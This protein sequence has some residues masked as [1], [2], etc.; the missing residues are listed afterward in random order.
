MLF[1]KMQKAGA[2]VRK[3]SQNRRRETGFSYNLFYG[4]MMKNIGGVF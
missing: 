4:K 2:K 3:F 1:L